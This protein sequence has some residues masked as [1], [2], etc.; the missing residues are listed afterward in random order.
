MGGRKEGGGKTHQTVAGG[1]DD[2]GIGMSPNET[3]IMA[4]ARAIF[5]PGAHV[6]VSLP[7]FDDETRPDELFHGGQL[8]VVLVTGHRQSIV[9]H[10]PILVMVMGHVV[11]NKHASLAH[12]SG[13]RYL[14]AVNPVALDGVHAWKWKRNLD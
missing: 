6:H 13:Y 2:L 4:L 7:P 10:W 12:F 9:N 14:V 11:R 8:D 1:Q 3:P 5:W